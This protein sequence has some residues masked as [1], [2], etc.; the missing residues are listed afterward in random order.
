MAVNIREKEQGMV[1]D[2]SARVATS[3]VAAMLTL[4]CFVCLAISCGG[5][6]IK[7]PGTAAP[8]P[9]AQPTPGKAMAL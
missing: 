3:R 4:L 5:D 6:N 1:P 9:T 8:V 7:F 2:V